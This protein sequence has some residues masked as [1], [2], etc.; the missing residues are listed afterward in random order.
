VN[1]IADEINTSGGHASVSHASVPQVI[2]I[3]NNHYLLQ[4]TPFLVE[5]IQDTALS[6]S[7]GATTT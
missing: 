3:M 5:D 6:H 1:K 7:S 2:F 4:A